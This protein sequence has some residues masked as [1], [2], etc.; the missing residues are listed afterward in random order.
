MTNEE[1]IKYITSRVQGRFYKQRVYAPN[2]FKDE[3]IGKNIE[4]L[5]GISFSKY[6]SYLEKSLDKSIIFEKKN[7][8]IDHILPLHRAMSSEEYLRRWNYKNT[9]LETA[10]RNKLKS[11]KYDHEMNYYKF[12]KEKHYLR[13][14]G[15]KMTKEIDKSWFNF[16]FGA[17]SIFLMNIERTLKLLYVFSESNNNVISTY[18]INNKNYYHRLSILKLE[19]DIMRYKS[20]TVLLKLVRF[21]RFPKEYIDHQGYLLKNQHK[22]NKVYSYLNYEYDKL[23]SSSTS[24]NLDLFLRMRELIEE[25][26]SNKCICD[27]VYNSLYRI[28]EEMIL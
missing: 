2:I 6:T 1:K 4:E 16:L 20:N 14:A 28:N 11:A 19:H 17:G 22:P 5:L 27:K 8:H 26:K 10:K 21:I 25:L 3:L 24:E 15:D 7:F 23:D 9:K 12:L 13:K 18:N